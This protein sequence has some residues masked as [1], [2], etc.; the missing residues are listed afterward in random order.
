MTPL[1]RT[2]TVRLA[3]V[4]LPLLGGCAS[5]GTVDAPLVTGS[6][7]P[8]AGYSLSEAE[9]R[10]DCIGLGR[11][12]DSDLETL[13]ALP[14]RAAVERAAAPST[15][16]AAANRLLADPEEQLEA[17]RALRPLAHRLAAFEAAMRAKGCPPLYREVRGVV[18][19]TARELGVAR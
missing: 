15:L 10:L 6:V 2:I 8:V 16:V 7:T 13:Q 19:A 17:T 9:A 5:G 14:M 18:D 1:R 11:T 4:A 12:I 3:T